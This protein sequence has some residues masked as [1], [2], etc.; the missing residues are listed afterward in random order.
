MGTHDD[1]TI[2][3]LAHQLRMFRWRT[4]YKL[5]QFSLVS[6]KRGVRRL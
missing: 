6:K 2:E 1:D 4:C 3:I 5:S